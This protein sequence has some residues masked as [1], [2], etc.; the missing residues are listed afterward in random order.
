MDHDSPAPEP[1]FKVAFDLGQ[2]EVAS[3]IAKTLAESSS[4]FAA[5]A[6]AMLTSPIY[7]AVEDAKRQ[8]NLSVARMVESATKPSPI[9]QMI[10]PSPVARM[11]QEAAKPSPIA[12]MIKPSP[13]ARMIQ[14]AAES[15]P[16]ASAKI[17]G[18]D[19][20]S[21][22]R[23][24]PTTHSLYADGAIPSLDE[25]SRQRFKREARLFSAQLH[26]PEL[27]EQLISRIDEQEAARR[28][29]RRDDRRR[30][31][32]TVAILLATLVAA[33]VVPIVLSIV[34][35]IV[36]SKPTSSPAPTA[37]RGG[38][39]TT[40][41]PVATPTRPPWFSGLPRW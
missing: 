23:P 32:I 9:A 39:V 19:A 14:E 38:T 8:A 16:S 12:Q 26:V 18:F 40:R 22:T 7:Q 30:F 33:I 41:A 13:V 4:G 36:L 25:L 11:I 34:M 5:T 2:A 28:E 31:R 35:P 6:K 17:A 3:G 1:K 29:D 27:L 24:V 15:L 21:L 20:A 37:Q 10:K